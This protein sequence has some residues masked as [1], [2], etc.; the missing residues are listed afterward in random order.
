MPADLTARTI[1]TTDQ[2]LELTARAIFASGFS[3]SVVDARWPG[4]REAFGRFKTGHVVALSDDDLDGISD[5]PRVIG[6][7]Q[8][9]AAVR[10]AAVF[11]SEKKAEHGSVRR[12]LT[13]LGDFDTRQRE[14]RRLRFIGAF[15]AYYVLSVAGF[16]VPDYDEWR[17]RY[18]PTMRAV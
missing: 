3:W 13:S 6:N 10:E 11:L 1:R 17:R 5:D 9:I 18:A 15:G 4:L 8:K 7:R 12:W 16:Y 14:L 2:F